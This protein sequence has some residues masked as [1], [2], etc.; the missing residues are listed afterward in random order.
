[1]ELLHHTVVLL[2]HLAPARIVMLPFLC[3]FRAPAEEQTEAAYQEVK[4]V[5]YVPRGEW[6]LTFKSTCTAQFKAAS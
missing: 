3:V 4:E 6:G 5:K 1:M 2:L